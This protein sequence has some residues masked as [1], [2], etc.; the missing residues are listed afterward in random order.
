MHKILIADAA[1]PWR[2]VLAR[3]MEEE[4]QVECCADGSEA[5]ERLEQFEPDVLILDMML[6]GADSL[7]V[8]QRAAAA[9]N[10]PKMIVTGTFFS[11][12]IT[13]ALNRCRVD[14]ALLK[15]CTISGMLDRVGELLAQSVPP[16]VHR[17]DPYDSVTALLLSLNVPTSQRGFH[18]LRDGILLMMEDPRQQLT[19]SLYPTIAKLHGTTPGNVEKCIRM[20]VTTAWKRRREECWRQ[21]FP[22]APNGQIARPTS[23]QF[24]SRM[25]DA[26]T[27]SLRRQ[28]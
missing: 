11:S 17:L 14:F 2:L 10:R 4:Y 12:F 8:L 25:A 24:L 16:M 3:A 6:S 7:S 15:P 21:Y 22:L 13:A 27:I 5:I 26:M 19:K 1:E 9:A 28:A 18:Y 23:G 20:T